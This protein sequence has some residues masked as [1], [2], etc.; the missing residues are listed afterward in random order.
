ML[1]WALPSATIKE[2]QCSLFWSGTRDADRPAHLR[3]GAEGED[4]AARYLRR[5]GYRIRDRNVRVDRDEIDI[6]A[7]DPLDKVL[8][9]IEVKT[10]S[11]PSLDFSPETNARFHKRR[12]LRRGI[13]RW[14][15]RHAYEG[16]FRLDLVCVVGK[17]IEHFKEI[18]EWG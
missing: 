1:H 7:F 13:A 4:M 10:R 6:I 12:K 2:V 5:L 18:G 9:F 16:A 14:I 3:V 15:T 11:M 8:V 17:E